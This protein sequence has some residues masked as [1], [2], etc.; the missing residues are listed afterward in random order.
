MFTLIATAALLSCSEA[1]SII[2]RIPPTAFTSREYVE[3]IY[4]IQ[5]VSPALCFSEETTSPIQYQRL[6]P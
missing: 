4:I 3:L 6:T 5:Q 1:T 2:N